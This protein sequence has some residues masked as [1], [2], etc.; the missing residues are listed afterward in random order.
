M[1]L[2]TCALAITAMFC[3]SLSSKYWVGFYVTNRDLDAGY[4]YDATSIYR[5]WASMMSSEPNGDG[6]CVV[7]KFAGYLYD[8]SC[9]SA[10]QFVCEQPGTSHFILNKNRFLLLTKL[11]LQKMPTT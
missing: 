3:R 6:P 2:I 5:R 10:Y 4:W 11:A 9:D 8:E 1:A 7:I